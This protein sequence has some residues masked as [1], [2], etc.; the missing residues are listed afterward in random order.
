MLAPTVATPTGNLTLDNDTAAE[1][2]FAASMRCGYIPTTEVTIFSAIFVE[3]MR[4]G[5]TGCAGRVATEFGDHPDLAVSRMRRVLAA[6]A[7][8]DLN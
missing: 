7:L 4:N 6:V 5:S 1:A 3:L 8:L 2:L